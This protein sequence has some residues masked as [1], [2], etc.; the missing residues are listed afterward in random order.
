MRAPAIVLVLAFLSGLSAA[1]ENPLSLLRVPLPKPA[2]PVTL[3]TSKALA[4]LEPDQ[5]CILGA[6]IDLDPNLSQIY[7]DG[8]GKNRKTP[9]E[10]ESKV[11][12]T[13]AMYFF[14]LGYGE[15]LPMDWV[16]R[17]GDQGKYVHI[18]YEPNGGLGE[19]EDNA[20]LRQFAADCRDSGAKIFIR[21]ASEMNGPW[22]KYSGNP[23][24]YREKFRLVAKVMHEVAPNVAMVWC[25]YTTPEKTIPD[26]YP[27]DEWVDWVG[28]N[29]YSVTYFNQNLSTPGSH[30]TPREMV[31]FVYNRWAAKKPM[32]ICEYAA[33]NYS[34]AENSDV[35]PFAMSKI[36]ALY[37]DLPKRFPRVKAIN[38]FSTNA[39]QLDHRKNNDYTITRVEQLT[40]M[41]RE[42]VS[43]PYFLKATPPPPVVYKE[44]APEEASYVEGDEISVGRLLEVSLPEGWDVSRV[45]FTVDGRVDN[46]VIE[47]GRWRWK[48]KTVGS[49][50]LGVEVLDPK[51]KTLAKRLYS[52]VVKP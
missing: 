29:M 24:A 25:P 8:T 2:K 39:L 37:Q 23:S 44:P 3:E 15:R 42:L 28:V 14:Y 22:T 5:G 48:A 13:H 20:Y 27:G 4:R 11:G 12:V 36:R 40:A 30:I 38:Y 19:V 41:Y 34:A 47:D 46:A 49:Q 26:Y 9:E 31:E 35:V 16:R 1:Q 10:F 43:Q 7:K 45:I 6:Y 50:I 33:T 51:G 18:A 21:F 52:V 32:M 17:L